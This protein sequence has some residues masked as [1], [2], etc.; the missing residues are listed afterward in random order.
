VFDR[1]VVTAVLAEWYCTRVVI[2]SV[3]CRRGVWRP[4]GSR[5][6]YADPHVVFTVQAAH[7]AL[8]LKDGE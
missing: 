8:F 2:V 5:I 1:H 4:C 3:G 7:S 6:F